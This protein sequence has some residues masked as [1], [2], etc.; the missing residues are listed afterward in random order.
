MC[1]ILFSFNQ[2]RSYKLIVAANRDEFYERKTAPADFWPDHRD[3]LGGR[4]LEA[5]GGGSGC[6]TWLGITRAGKI[7]MLTNY[8]DP[9]H[10]DPAAPSRGKLVSDYLRTETEPMEYL[11]EVVIRAAEFNGF[12]LIAGD[13]NRLFY[14][15]NYAQ[16]IREI[17]PGLY[18]LS[19]H[20]LETPWPKVVKA[21]E[22]IGRLM[23][24]AQPDPEV[25]LSSLYDDRQAP[26]DLLPNTGV[27][28]ER[29]RM[30]SPIFIKSPQYGSRCSTVVMV[31]R[32]NHVHF[33]ERVYD[34]NDF[35]YTSSRF[36]FTIEPQRA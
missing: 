11:K 15:S 2:H 18:G 13:A 8:R 20:L 32:S 14:Y 26:D 29:E 1:L 23:E 28:L 19:N 25:L 16:G 33:S 21:K 22:K 36:D 6:G 17:Q 27:G 24:V 12:N 7:S 35:S 4:D 30:L 31:D 10:I 9:A 5:C 34:L 3:I